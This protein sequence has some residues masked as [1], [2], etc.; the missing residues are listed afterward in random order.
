MQSV[1]FH[2]FSYPGPPMLGLKVCSEACKLVFDILKNIFKLI[3]IH[4]IL[5]HVHT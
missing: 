5:E 1:G 2:L 3:N 4:E